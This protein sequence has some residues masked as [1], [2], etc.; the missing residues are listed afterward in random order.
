MN[1]RIKILKAFFKNTKSQIAFIVLCVFLISVLMNLF[2]ILLTDYRENFVRQHRAL[3]AEHI[4]FVGQ[5][6][7]F[8]LLERETS[9]IL[10]KKSE[11]T[12]IEINKVYYA[13]CNFD[14]DGQTLE[15]HLCYMPEGE[16]TEKKIGKIEI[17]SREDGKD[18]V[19]LPYIFEI[20]GGYKI[21]DLF[22]VSDGSHDL[23]L[24]VV[25]FFSN[26]MSATQNCGYM[27]ILFSK[28]METEVSNY[29]EKESLLCSIRLKSPGD[30]RKMEMTVSD[31]ITNGIPGTTVAVTN[32]YDAVFGGRYVMETISM[33]I[34]GGMVVLLIVL[35]V[36]IVSSN[37]ALYI[38]DHKSMFGILE[39]IGY[40]SHD[41]ILSVVPAVILLVFFVT[42]LGIAASYLFFPLFNHILETQT[43]MPYRE[44]FILL[45]ALITIG[46][47]L[48]SVS[49]SVFLSMQKLHKITPL[50]AIRSA[51]ASSHSTQNK[52]TVRN[53]RLPLNL[54][55][56]VQS[57]C[58]N[59]SQNILIFVAVFLS[60]FL[61]T[62]GASLLQNILINDVT[63]ASFVLGEFAD[64][65][66]VISDRDCVEICSNLDRNPEVKNYVGYQV[67]QA[68]SEEGEYLSAVVIEG[69]ERLTNTAY[70]Y[71]GK[72]PSSIGEAAIGGKF[73]KENGI[74]IGDTVSVSIAGKQAKLKVCGFLQ[75]AMY[76]GYDIA[77]TKE[78][79]E[80][81]V[82]LQTY[83]YYIYLD[84]DTDVAHFNKELARDNP[85]L[86]LS[87]MRSNLEGLKQIYFSGIKW[88]C[89]MMI[90]IS[91]VMVFLILYILIQNLL[92]RKKDDYGIMKAL[93]YSSKTL[94]LHTVLTYLPGIIIA[95]VIGSAISGLTF[96][97]IMS[98][99]L[100]GIG[101][102]K[103]NFEIPWLLIAGIGLAVVI[104]CCI[105]TMI[106][107]GKIKR[108]E[109]RDLLSN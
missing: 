85:I 84:K 42:V 94:M 98:C 92:E 68:G 67:I 4:S 51:K 31:E 45:P 78:C 40:T 50:D 6:A 93:G 56:P 35:T 60:V 58:A 13:W 5:N 54:A 44:H 57:M 46:T 38:S 100:M 26:A 36:F 48:F 39:A 53:L 27:V 32:K 7:D 91:L 107:S 105:F 83:R 62:F 28:G 96:N 109:V 71:L 24:P 106:V 55:I 95:T 33:A 52:I 87:D 21:G 79:C 12:E 61:C 97:L 99:L 19:I 73:A 64:S 89:G 77:L 63:I 43:G 81:I 47:L 18:G 29:F 72:M 25:G 15:S 20:G 108:I 59:R 70:C 23:S 41:M 66:I 104:F 37:I 80:Q 103:C 10:S 34:I 22:T 14:Y 86:F 8:D 49:F 9:R 3:H 69:A 75:S 90:T 17:L 16:G 82:P 30:N 88:L 76:L 11:L 65:S 2:L 74:E 1:K 101:I 102:Q